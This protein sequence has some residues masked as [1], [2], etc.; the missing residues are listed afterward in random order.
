[1]KRT[2][3]VV[4]LDRGFPLVEFENGTEIRCEHATAI[5]K[6]EERARAVVGDQVEVELPEGHDKGIIRSILPRRTRFVR[7]DPAE[8]T[9]SQVLAANFDLVMVVEPIVQLNRKRLERELVLAHETRAR[10]AIVLTKA[11]L[12]EDAAAVRREVA[13]LAGH[14]VAVIASSREDAR[15]IGRVRDLV[16]VGEIAILIGK[17]GVGKSSLVNALAGSDVQSTASVRE[18]DGKGRHTTV[19]RVLVKLPGGGGVVDM[20]GIRGLGLWDADQGLGVAFADVE[21]LASHCKFRDCSHVNE[22]GCAVQEAVASGALA[23]T[24]LESY[25]SLAAEIASVRTQRTEASR[26]RGEKASDRR[27][28]RRR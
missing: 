17:S 27:K 9:S 10:V 2:G 8:R 14:S 3:I 1:M 24:R 23:A 18:R 20:P 6:D 4:R 21:E 16:G 25:R 7:K 19:E 12:C 26:M 15:S 5:V 11:D 13:D 22:P 28:R